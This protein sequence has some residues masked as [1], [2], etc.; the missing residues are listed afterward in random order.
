[1]PN[2]K[3]KRMKKK[4]LN[5]KKSLLRLQLSR[6][7][8]RKKKP[9]E[10]P[11]QLLKKRPKEPKKLILPSKKPNWQSSRTQRKKPI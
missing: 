9:R 6:L 7:K 8:I 5:S 4:N 10:L 2:Y 3:L 11:R 1:M